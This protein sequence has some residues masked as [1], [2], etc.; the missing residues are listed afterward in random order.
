MAWS[1]EV[2]IK[3][4]V[5]PSMANFKELTVPEA[6]KACLA[7]YGKLPR[8]GY[9]MTVAEQ[10]PIEGAFLLSRTGY[11]TFLVNECGDFRVWTYFR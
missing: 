4:S 1:P 2:K 5:H 7:K 6:K 9:E 11:T 3:V 8:C 10:E